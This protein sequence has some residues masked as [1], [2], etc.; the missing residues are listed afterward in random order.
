[1]LAEKGLIDKSLGDTNDPLGFLI[2]DGGAANMTEAA[3]RY[4]R[5]E[6]G[7]DIVLFGTGDA[8]HL[9]ENI[10][11]STSRRCRRPIARSSMRCSATWRS[12]SGSTAMMG[13]R[14]SG[15]LSSD[16]LNL[17]PSP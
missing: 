5:H 8:E 3:Y 13:G 17:N 11:R 4:V 10:R 16:R 2:H 12:A 1:M 6:P 14:G 7:V 15:F 9:R